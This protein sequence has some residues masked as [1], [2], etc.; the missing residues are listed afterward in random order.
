MVSLEGTL[1]LETEVFALLSTE[2]AELDVA[3]SQVKASDLLVEDLG[4]DV[5]TN[6]ELASLGE[7]DILLTESLVLGL[8]QHDLGK[9]LV[10][11]RA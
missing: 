11:E 3:V 10:G 6:V 1:N 2:G 5:D 4:Q 8:E 7:S 9:D